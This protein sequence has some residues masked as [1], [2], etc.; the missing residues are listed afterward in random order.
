M[1]RGS[2]TSIAEALP[3]EAEI[4]LH[5]TEMVVVRLHPDENG[6]L[7]QEDIEGKSFGQIQRMGARY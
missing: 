4:R 5:T 1:I 2:E 6:S 3:S 7:L